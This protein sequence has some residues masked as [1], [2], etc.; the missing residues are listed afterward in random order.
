MRKREVRR[1]EMNAQHRM[2]LV[3]CTALVAVVVSSQS[4]AGAQLCG[5]EVACGATVN[6]PC[7]AFDVN[8][9]RVAGKVEAFGNPPKAVCVY[10]APPPP[11]G[12]QPLASSVTQPGGGD[13]YLWR[14]APAGRAEAPPPGSWSADAPTEHA[15]RQV[16]APS[17]RPVE[18]RKPEPPMET[19]RC[20]QAR[21]KCGK[22]IVNG[23]SCV[24]KR[25]SELVQG[26]IQCSDSPCTRKTATCEFTI[27]VL[28][29]MEGVE[30]QRP[31]QPG[32]VTTQY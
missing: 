18:D 2:L 23:E 32:Q 5:G 6:D 29:H 16:V 21:V 12:T 13:A 11:K 25:G 30:S 28:E 15:E 8:G 20:D 31:Q 3:W 9:V 26:K 4:F 19:V 1:L 27:T 10:E 24:G 14:E 7:Y 22:S 17:R